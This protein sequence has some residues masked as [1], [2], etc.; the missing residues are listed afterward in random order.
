M[1]Y[2]LRVSQGGHLVFMASISELYARS[3][4]LLSMV[5]SKHLEE[6]PSH[7]PVLLGRVVLTVED[8]LQTNN[9]AHKAWTDL[10]ATGHSVPVE[11]EIIGL[12][13]YAETGLGSG[14]GG[15]GGEGAWP[16]GGGGGGGN[17][18]EAGGAG[19]GGG[20][21]ALALLVFDEEGNI[22]DVE[23][24]VTEGSSN[25][26]CQAGMH[27]VK[28]ILIGGGGGGGNGGQ[29]AYLDAKQYSFRSPYFVYPIVYSAIAGG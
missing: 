23:V 6:E 10:Y 21:G 14:V 16:G 9:L 15:A 4:A 24:F 28:A 27:K 20:G 19:G 18:E 29:G 12:K 2:F 17:G 13:T 7:A 22:F 1:A 8:A 26:V 3:L 5:L 25:W 11:L